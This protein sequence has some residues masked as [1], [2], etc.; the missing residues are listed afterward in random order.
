MSYRP[1]YCFLNMNT[2]FNRI[3]QSI[4]GKLRPPAPAQTLQAEFDFGQSPD[5][6]ATVRLNLATKNISHLLD[7]ITA[8]FASGARELRLELL[9][10]GFLLHDHALMLFDELLNRPEGMKLH[11]H[12]RTSLS[13]GAIL[14]WLVGDTRSI[15]WD[16]WIQ[17]SSTPPLPDLVDDGGC[18]DAVQVAGEEPSHTDLR[19]IMNYMEEW[20]PISEVAGLRLFNQD[21]EELGLLEDD[22][23]CRQL[24][25]LFEG[26]TEPP[27]TP[28]TAPTP[29]SPCSPQ[30]PACKTSRD[31]AR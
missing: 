3:I 12:S 9:G 21:L 15:R 1:H 14:L 31:R 26:S 6:S 29:D 28:L 19:T 18:S 2:R 10:P 25:A 23:S 5:P 27:K 4:A 13:D 11:V 30:V 17:L 8:A 20:L 22:A 16:A 24:D 7:T